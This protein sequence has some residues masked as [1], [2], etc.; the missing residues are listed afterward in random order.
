MLQTD[1][2]QLHGLY[3][4]PDKDGE[5]TILHLAIELMDVPLSASG[6]WDKRELILVI[7]EIQFHF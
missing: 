4:H 1:A 3:I 7:G 2:F 5:K 6:L